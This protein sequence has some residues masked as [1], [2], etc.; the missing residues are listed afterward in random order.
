M[1]V[2]RD[3]HT[4]YLAATAVERK[5]PT[6]HAVKWLHGIL[7][8]LG[9]RRLHLQSDSEASNC[10]LKAAVTVASLGVEI[11]PRESPPGEHASN[12]EVEVAV[13]EVKRRIRVLR[14]ALEQRLGSTVPDDHVFLRWLP[15]V[16]G[17]AISHFRLGAD[18]MTAEVRRSGRPWKRMVA[19][20][21]ERV[22]YRPA[23]AAV[24][25]S[26]MAAKLLAGYYVGHH[27]RTGVLLVLTK[28]GLVKAAG[29][30]R[31]PPQE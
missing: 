3:R 5:G 12:G 14:F 1:L 30:R 20:V 10:A 27:A 18:G 31:A 21:G 6:D 25:R 4:G 2:V 13:R 8:H 15:M 22:F 11:I 23:T 7:R 19:E 16:A 9:Y 29:F 26:G 28:E 17:N 24:P